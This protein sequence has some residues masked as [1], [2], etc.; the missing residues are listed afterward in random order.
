MYFRNSVFVVFLLA[1]AG[2]TSA[3][4]STVNGMPNRWD[5]QMCLDYAKKNNIQ[6][7]MLRLSEKTAEQ[8]YL[9]SKAARQPTLTGTVPIT[10][11]HSNKQVS[12]V[13]GGF[14]TQSS[15]AQSFTLGSGV[16]IYNGG[17]ISND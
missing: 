14:Q 3:Q 7:N 12:G 11:T 2:M 9:L 1:F 13:I 5:L 15:F 17:Y 4:D 8:N 10:Y 16:T 6:L